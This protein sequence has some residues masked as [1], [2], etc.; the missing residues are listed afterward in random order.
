MR[1]GPKQGERR[2][3][4]SSVVFREH[5]VQSKQAGRGKLEKEGT[6]E[7]RTTDFRGYRARGFSKTGTEINRRGKAKWAAQAPAP[8]EPNC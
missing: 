6:D 3:G 5:Y 7:A 8:P 4:Q 2:R 1:M